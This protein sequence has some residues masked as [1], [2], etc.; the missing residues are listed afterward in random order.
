[1]QNGLQTKELMSHKR[2]RT[3][4]GSGSGALTPESC[5]DVF[6]K[7]FRVQSAQIASLES[8]CN[9]QQRRLNGQELHIRFIETKLD[10]AL[11]AIVEMSAPLKPSQLNRPAKRGKF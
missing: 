8:R 5:G 4:Y 11:A 7:G 2:K 6:T 9:A 1:M 3:S 10:R